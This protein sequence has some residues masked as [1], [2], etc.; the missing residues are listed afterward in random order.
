MVVTQANA[1][2]RQAEQLVTRFVRRFEPSYKWFLYYAALPLVLTPELLNYLRNK[3]LRDRHVPWVAEVD[4]LLSDLCAPVGDEQYSMDSRVRDYLIRE[5]ALELGQPELERVAK[6]LIRYVEQLAQI[7]QYLTWQERRAQKWAAMVIVE[8]ERERV[9]E[10]IAAA[11][12]D[13]DAKDTER[14]KALSLASQAEMI[15]LS[16]IT[17]RLAPQLVEHEALVQYARSVTQALYQ[18]ESLEPVQ[19]QQ[20]FQVGDVTLTLPNASKPT[21][22]VD[23]GLQTLNFIH[24]QLIDSDEEAPD[25]SWSLKTATFTVATVSL[26]DESSQLG[27]QPFDFTVATLKHRSDQPTAT[28]WVIQRQQQRAYHFVERLTEDLPLEMVAIPGGTFTMGSPTDELGHQ[29]REAPQ[30]KVTVPDF[31][32]GRYPITQAQWRFVANLPSV[33]GE[34]I[35]D[36]SR[37]KGNRLPVEKVSWYDATE[38]CRRLSQYTQRQYRFPTEAEWEYA[39][40][41]RTTTPFHFGET[42]TTDLANYNGSAYIDEPK[43]DRRGKTTPV[44]E[45]EAANGFGLSDMHGNVREWCQDHWHENYS[46]A[47]TDGSAWSTDNERT[48]RV[49]R[50]GSWDSSPRYCRS[51]F[52]YNFTPVSRGTYTGFRVSCSAPRT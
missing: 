44:G 23:F 19:L 45:F 24:G 47:P 48:R 3:F 30:H 36:P 46:G 28:K 16:R 34:L 5:A 32:M 8:A 51:A 27:L 33:S 10:D 9:A 20:T 4:L 35:P 6:L 29:S 40:R 49:V 18:P 1:S 25:A 39:C 37:F 15:R 31:L 11:F 41:G 43:G 26:G 2:D 38:F 22:P 50:G 52:R 42:I 21:Q 12:Q 14:S 17:E 7:N 13:C